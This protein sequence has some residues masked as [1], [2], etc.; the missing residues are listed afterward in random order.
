[1]FEAYSVGVRVSLLAGGVT[2]GLLAM[3]K[4]FGK[5]HGDV[6]GLQRK[7]DKIGR[8]MLIGGAVTGAGLGLFGLMAKT[9]PAAT[10]YARQLN[11]MNRAGLTQVEIAQATGA[12]WKNTG[13]VITTTATENLRSMMDLRSVLGSMQDAKW[14][15]PIVSKISTVMALSSTGKIDEKAGENTAFAMA[16][17][18]D[19][20]GAAKGQQTFERQAGEMSKV[21]TAFQ[22]R[23]SPQQFQGVF[24]Y[25]RQ[26]KFDMSDEFKY[27]ILPT[28]MLEAGG[29]GKSGGGG[30]RGVGPMVAAMYRFTNQ[31]YIN[32][33]AIPLLDKL[34]LLTSKEFTKT[35]TPDTVGAKLVG[36]DLAAKNSFFWEQQVVGPAIRKMLGIGA[37]DHSDK[38]EGRIR[39]VLNMAL[40]GNQLAAAGMAE[41]ESK[42]QNFYRDQK[43]IQ[44]AMPYDAAY[45]Q[46]I[47][48][49][50]EAQMIAL[51]A[52][53]RNAMIPLGTAILPDLI[54]VVKSLTPVL[55]DFATWA[56]KNPDGV[57]KFT[58]SIGALAGV[59]TLAGAV[60]ITKATLDA[61]GLLLGIVK[62]L[63]L[64]A[65]GF[66]LL[67]IPLGGLVS[68][69][70]WPAILIA[71]GLVAIGA[72]FWAIWKNWD[73]TK[74]V[75]ANI[76]S[77]LGRFFTWIANKA[78]ALVGLGP[79]APAADAGA[80]ISP[81]P[82]WGGPPKS[83]MSNYQGTA[84]SWG[85]P[86][87]PNAPANQNGNTEVNVY[88]DS[89]K[90]VPAVVDRIQKGMNRAPTGGSTYD[91]RASL[92][93]A[94]GY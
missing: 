7:L 56:Q 80:K 91:P 81:P 42:P 57:Q 64:I 73:G 21:I 38:A 49:D 74:G 17:A 40:R 85:A 93:H 1:M 25:A 44:G 54:S 76:T 23:V 10:E 16:K 82:A 2:A 92:P 61:L 90:I 78:R 89:K 24:Q 50:P 29:S 68:F 63:P 11:I 4:S 59:L 77:E 62:F 19:I 8:T 13:D 69:F 75:W 28:L 84:G 35:T 37:D 18:L 45:Q 87:T 71:A 46:A 39:T 65:T 48:S 6:D 34:G 88:L 66:R 70:G 5:V 47:K 79:L 94:A 33:K 51:K 43:L 41:Y 36:A 9:L 83:M 60:L 22:N 58:R 30:S 32:K 52:Q 67:L 27:E 55:H 53:W 15:L 86:L 3:S 20:I 72:A 31:G 12:A 14:A 26:A